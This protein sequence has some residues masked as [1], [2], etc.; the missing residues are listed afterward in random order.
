MQ[1]VSSQER[2][3]PAAYSSP[4]STKHSSCPSQ[5]HP[6]LHGLCAA[7][8]VQRWQAAVCRGSAF[9]IARRESFTACQ[10]S[11][12]TTDS[13][14][15]SYYSIVGPAGGLCAS[16]KTP[17][18]PGRDADRIGPGTVVPRCRQGEDRRFKSTVWG[19]NSLSWY[20]QIRAT[21][22]SGAV[23]SKR[24]AGPRLG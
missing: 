24:L 6:R 20:C 23:G 2:L 10:E 14:T 5:P 4:S 22:K 3:D 15:V 12:D 8:A 19:Y 13:R 17:A 1:R 18:W 7:G 16:R 11:L 21:F 9:M